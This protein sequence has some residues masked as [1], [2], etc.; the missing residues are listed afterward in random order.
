MIRYTD[1]KE[2]P[3]GSDKWHKLRNS[4]VSGTDA[5]DLLCGKPIEEI[6]LDKAKPFA[7]NYATKRGHLLEEE[8]KEI[9]SKLYQ[10][11]TNIG[12]VTNEKYPNALMSPDGVIFQDNIPIALVEVKCFNEKRHFQVYESLD[13]HIIAQIQFGLLITELPWCDLVLYNPDV[14]DLDQ[15]FLT[16]RIYPDPKIHAR[17]RELLSNPPKATLDE[18]ASELA[19]NI[20]ETELALQSNEQFKQ[21]LV[22]TQELEQMKQDLK[23]YLKDKMSK[24]HVKEVVSPNGKEDWYATYS[25]T[26]TVKCVDQSSIP[27]DFL[28]VEEIENAIIKNGKAFKV[29]PNTNLVRELD[30]IGGTIPEGFEIKTVPRLSIKLNNKPLK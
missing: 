2:V 21:F 29:T 6:L 13:A 30:K 28:I 17:L 25:E 9:Y 23:N 4:K 12:V 16:R 15:T 10:P 22:A 20:A 14:T 1:A 5:Y 18:T 11:T 7:G 8:A 26:H 19:K 27:D 3:Q 24:E